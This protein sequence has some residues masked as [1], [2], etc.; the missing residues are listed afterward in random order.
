[1][2]PRYVEDALVISVQSF[3]I[4]GMHPHMENKNG[5][6][7][8]MSETDYGIFTFS[9]SINELVAYSYQLIIPCFNRN[10]IPLINSSSDINPEDHHLAICLTQSGIVFSSEVLAGKP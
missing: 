1:M 8:L 9:M 10:S 2:I 7:L 3:E 4:S 6:I 5:N